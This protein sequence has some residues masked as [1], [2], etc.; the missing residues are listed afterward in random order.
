MSKILIVDDNKKN[1]EILED[2]LAAWGYEAFTADEG[3]KALNSALELEPAVILLDVMLPGMNGFELCKKL[4]MGQT[5]KDIPVIMI[6]ALNEV[7]DR[8][9]GFNAG[10]DVFL[11]RPV[12]YQEL[13]NRVEW[14]VNFRKKLN[15]M[16]NMKSVVKSFVAIMKLKDEKLYSHAINVKNY[17]EKVVKLFSITDEQE[18]KILTAACLMDIG[19]LASDSEQEHIDKGVSIIAPL[20][21]GEWLKVF[22]ER[23]HDRK[24][25]AEASL[26]AQVLTTVN[27]F[28]ELWEQSGSKDTAEQSL[29]K[30]CREGF[31][32][33]EVLEAISQVLKDESFVRSI[34]LGL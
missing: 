19:K 5:T 6:T 7:E 16:E 1:C 26:E 11:S 30:E 20:K 24:C 22:I 23:H 8:I 2:L 14:A 9:R 21:A 10:A 27:R 33:T 32:S 3:V 34:K 12:V 28:V 18:E 25:R 31:W 13:K 15:E 29:R 4:K 17:C